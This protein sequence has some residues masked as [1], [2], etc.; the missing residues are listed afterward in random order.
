[1]IE[2]GLAGAG[3]QKPLQAMRRLADADVPRH[4]VKRI[5]VRTGM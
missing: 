4:R 3:E 5:A 1:L 2:L